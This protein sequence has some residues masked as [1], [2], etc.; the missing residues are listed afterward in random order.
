PFNIHKI[1]SN[2]VRPPEQ[3]S[4]TVRATETP[5]IFERFEKINPHT[6]IGYR[7]VFGAEPPQ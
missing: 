5:H 1:G 3:A 7:T 6:P 4:E 2:S